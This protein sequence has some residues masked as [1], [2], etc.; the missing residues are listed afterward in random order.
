ME[1]MG[2]GEENL[3]MSPKERAKVTLLVIEPDPVERNNMRNALRNLGFGGSSDVPNHMAGIEKMGQR[4]YTHVIFD[5]K[6]SNMPTD[7]FVQKVLEVNKGIVCIPSSYEPNVDDVFNLLCLGAKGYLVK[8]FTVD[9]L[10]MAIVNATKGEPLS[11]AIIGAKDRNEALI[12]VVMQSLDKVALVLRQAQQFETAKRE[13]PRVMA[14]MR[15]AA[16]LAHTFCKDGEEGL[17]AALEK[18]CI[19]RSKGPATRLGRL[20]KRLKTK[21]VEEA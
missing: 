8:P 10:D 21:R 11:E 2:P 6:K 12:A 9:S 18:F 14:Q 16:D 7:A 15:R 17:L 3:A 13:V 1:T 4:Q 19:E 20:R 5:A